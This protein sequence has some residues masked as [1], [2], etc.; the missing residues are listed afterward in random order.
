MHDSYVAGLR[1]RLYLLMSAHMSSFGRTN[2]E[3]ADALQ[4]AFVSILYFDNK[5]GPAI[6]VSVHSFDQLVSDYSHH[7]RNLNSSTFHV[8]EGRSPVL[9][10][11]QSPVHDLSFDNQEVCPRSHFRYFLQY[12]R[13]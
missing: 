13:K 1:L 6:L 10:L 5:E 11:I 7:F 9:T 3:G 4:R 12:M 8:T 2:E